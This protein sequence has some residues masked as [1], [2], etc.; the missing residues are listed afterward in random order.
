MRLV[1][2]INMDVSEFALSF[3]KTEQTMLQC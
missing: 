1:L 2:N 3:L